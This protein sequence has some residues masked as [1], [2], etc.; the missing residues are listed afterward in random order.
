VW[1]AG[2]EELRTRC[3]CTTDQQALALVAIMAAWLHRECHAQQQPRD[4]EEEERQQGGADA[5]TIWGQRRVERCD[6]NGG[7]RPAQ[8]RRGRER[9]RLRAHEAGVGCGVWDVGCGVW[10]VGCGMRT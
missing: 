5:G 1:D 7:A 8:Q 6:H 4:A 10:G 9:L 3:A 2:G